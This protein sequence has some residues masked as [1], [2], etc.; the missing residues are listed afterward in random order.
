M[1]FSSNLVEITGGLPRIHTTG[2]SY[3]E[4]AITNLTTLTEAIQ[5]SYDMIAEN[6]VQPSGLYS[7]ET[8][9]YWSPIEKRSD[10]QGRYTNRVWH[11]FQVRPPSHMV[12][13]ILQPGA[14]GRNGYD[15]DLPDLV[16][17]QDAHFQFSTRLPEG[18]M[19]LTITSF[20]PAIPKD[21]PFE[22][23]SAQV[24]VM[25]PNITSTLDTPEITMIDTDGDG[26]NDKVVFSFGN[27]TN[28]RTLAQ[29]DPVYL[30][31]SLLTSANSRMKVRLIDESTM[32][33]G[34]NSEVMIESYLFDAINT[35]DNNC[36]LRVLKG[37]F[38]VFTAK[39]TDT[40]PDKFHVKTRM[41]TIGIRGCELGFELSEESEN[42]Y[43]FEIGDEEK[44]VIDADGKKKYSCRRTTS[45]PASNC[46]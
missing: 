5:F 24:L 39:I 13:S 33:Q 43:I 38:R 20:L 11:A 30:N 15:P 14:S 36:T 22:I 6:T 12:Q 17:G 29:N 34:A 37:I 4:F 1:A 44:I 27:V 31:D 19:P 45:W 8:T 7:N 28:T 9:L 35:E 16:I 25:G 10:L 2:V 32:A 23:K 40:N 46:I 18:T 21:D 26:M 42:V 41:A 3:V